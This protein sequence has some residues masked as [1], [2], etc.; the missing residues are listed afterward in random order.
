VALL[1]LEIITFG[2]PVLQDEV[3]M[4]EATGTLGEFGILPGHVPFVTTLEIGEI[5]YIKGGKTKFLAGGGGLA[6]VVDDK[7]TFLLDTAEFA[8]EIDI[9]RARRTEEIA[10]AMLQELA[11]DH[12]EYRRYEL[13]LLRAIARLQVA[14]K[15]L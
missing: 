7:V 1:N 2:G 6:E 4:V 3:D 8:E 10:R 14:S 13:M 11:V 5:R 9:D 12:S 15:K